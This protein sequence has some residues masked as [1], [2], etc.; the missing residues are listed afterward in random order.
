M[1]YRDHV[2]ACAEQ[3]RSGKSETVYNRSPAHA[4]IIVEH[5]FAFAD[6]TVDVLTGHL[7][8]VVY[9]QAPVLEA[10][11]DFARKGGKLRI[12]MEDVQAHHA[13][14]NALIA[15][16]KVENLMGAVD[17]RCVPATLETAYPYHFAV[18]DGRSF[19][20][21]GDKRDTQAVG[22]FGDVEVGQALQDRF[23][24]IWKSS[25]AVSL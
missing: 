15:R 4:S 2:R 8:T 5:L 10:A 22:A 19:R 18:A 23:N 3:G 21:E 20:M 24:E 1:T 12:L 16:L 13:Q 14:G 6:H 7:N 25:T 11:V 9:G 17:A